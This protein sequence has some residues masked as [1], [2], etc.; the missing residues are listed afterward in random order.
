VDNKTYVNGQF[1]NED[2]YSSRVNDTALLSTNYAL[3]QSLFFN[4]SATFFGMDYNFL[5]NKSKQLLLNGF[6][7]RDNFSHEVRIRLNFLKAWSFLSNNSGGYKTYSSQFFKTR[8]YKIEF[9]DLEEKLSFQPSTAFRISG[10]FKY[11]QK[12]NLGEG[13]F[14]KALINDYA[15]EMRYNQSE[16]GS[17]NLRADF[18]T[19]AYN[20]VESSPIA[21]EMLNALKPGYNY[22]WTI[23]YQRN[24]TGNIQI[25]INYDGR[26]SPNNK[27]VHIGGAQVR[28]FF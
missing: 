11:T 12:Q 21:Y 13:G 23:N 18:L 14:Q 22:T 5:N 16:K 27:I 25:S 4:Q 7:A 2:F 10:I 19:I 17:F 24:L 9:Y 28:A 1:F 3:R 20:D 6:D 8:N 15:I 26:K